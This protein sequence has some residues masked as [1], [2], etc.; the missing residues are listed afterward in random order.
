MVQGWVTT[1]VLGFGIAV[2]VVGVIAYLRMFRKDRLSSTSHQADD[3]SPPNVFISAKSTDGGH[4]KEAKPE[5][6]TPQD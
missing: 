3:V 4:K 6:A 2:A 5:Q 1:L